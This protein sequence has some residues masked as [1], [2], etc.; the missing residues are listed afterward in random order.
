MA[1]PLQRL[2]ET[3]LSDLRRGADV[4]KLRILHLLERDRFGVSTLDPEI[5]RQVE[6]GRYGAVAREE[7]RD[8]LESRDRA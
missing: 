4:E 2:W 8:F 3:F 1:D 6:D 7:W 5:R